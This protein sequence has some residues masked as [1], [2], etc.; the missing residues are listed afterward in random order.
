MTDKDPVAK[1]PGLR[2][3]KIERTRRQIA[4]AALQAFLERGYESATLEQIAEAADVHKRTLLRYFPTKAHLVLY[5]QHAALEEF[6]MA[7][8]E[9]GVRSIVDVWSDH[10]ILHSKELSR[11]GPAA[12]VRQIAASEP[13]V[14]QAYSEISAAYQDII[15]TELEAELGDDL[16]S[17][18]KARVAA[19]AFA[20][21]N[22]AVGGMILA[23]SDYASLEM[24]ERE[25]LRLVIEGVLSA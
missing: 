15:T 18:I 13:A 5:D 16:G 25:V 20:A 3:R 2:Q 14:R 12:N 24:A 17:R 23:H 11:R 21:G 6:R 22:Y 7:A 1:K 8:R 19:A 10:V 4:E 9:R